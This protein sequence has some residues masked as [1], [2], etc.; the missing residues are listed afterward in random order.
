MLSV[1]SPQAFQQGTEVKVLDVRESTNQIKVVSVCGKS[2]S[3]E[4]TPVSCARQQH[5]MCRRT[6]E[7]SFTCTKCDNEFNLRVW[8]QGATT[9]RRVSPRPTPE[10]FHTQYDTVCVLHR[11][12]TLKSL[13]I[14]EVRH[15]TR[16]PKRRGRQS[17]LERTRES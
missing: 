11:C 1:K 9:G 15:L 4:D 3:M 6:K 12:G 13:H 7:K 2:N 16:L 5:E 10:K 14:K 17:F 8:T